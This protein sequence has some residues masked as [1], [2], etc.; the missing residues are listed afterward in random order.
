MK[1][2]KKIIL[3]SLAAI[4]L[5]VAAIAITAVLLVKNSASF[6]HYLMAKAAD[7]I[8]E[9]S[10]A[11]LEA[12]DFTLDLS[13]LSVDLRNVVLRGAEPADAEPLLEAEHL[14]IGITVD[15]VLRRKWHFR[16]GMLSHPVVHLF[17]NRAGESNLPR[18]QGKA[19]GSTAGMFDL[20]IRRLVLERG[21]VYYN[22][23]KRQLD[24]DL[25]HL[26]LAVGFD[27]TQ[28][29]Y[30]GH[31]SYDQGHV[32][33]GSYAPP[34][35]SLDASFSAT[36][37]KLT[38]D[39]LQ[40]ATEKSQIV[41]NA[42]VEDY[43]NPRVQANYDASLA[44]FELA[45]V[46]KSPPVA[47]GTVRLTGFLKYQNQPGHP[48]LETLSLW[49]MLS[50]PELQVRAPHLQTTVRN[51]GA[52]Y[53][54]EGGNVEVQNLR[55]ELLGGT[56]EGSAFVRDLTGAGQ[57][58]LEAKL[59][60][61]SLTVLQTAS[62]T[63]PLR[64]AHLEGTINA[65]AE[66]SWAKALKNLVARGNMTIKAA[67][68]QNPPTPLD[69]VIHADYSA[70]SQQVALHQSYL[71]T[72]RNSLAL[73]G[74][75]SRLSQ[76]QFRLQARD[77]HE[78]ELLAGNFMPAQKLDLHGTASLDGSVSGS[79]DNPQVRAQLTA[80]NLR[81]KGTSWK[82]L[83]TG[84]SASPA[85]VS[86]S[87]G[88]LAA[89]Q[90]RIN[91]NV[92]S[93]LKQWTYSPLNQVTAR[94]S[95][96]QV[97]LAG[98]QRLA[99]K[100]YP[101]QGT[102]ALN[103]SVHGTQ[104]NPVGR[105]NVTLTKVKIADE[106]VQLVEAQ[107]QGDGDQVNA[108][109]HA[110]MPAGNIEGTLTYH[111]KTESY[112]GSLQGNDIR[113]EKLSTPAVYH[114]ALSGGMNLHVEG[115]GTLE[116][117]ELVAT[118]AV[119]QLQAQKQA[120]QGLN[121]EVRLQNRIANITLGSEVVA[122]SVKGHGTV[123]IE[124]PYPADLRLDTG[125]IALQSLLA[126]RAPGKMQGVTGET[127]LHASIQGPLADK[128]RLEV[129][130]E[131]PVLTASYKQF[132]LAATSP[133]RLD[134]Q[135][136]VAVL[137]P[138]S[139]QGTGAD[140]QMQA[141][142]PVNNPMAA[143]YLVQGTI[144]LRNAQLLQP[145]LDC[146]G[147]IEFD[148][149]SRRYAAGSDIAGEVRI[150]DASVHTAALPMG[151]DRGN[152]LVR[153]TKDRLDITD[154][155]G[156]V[157]GGTVTVKGGVVYQPRM[158]FNLALAAK[159]MRLRYPQGL[160]TVLDSNLS[161]AGTEQAAVLS[162]QAL[163]DHVSFT[164]EFKLS[165]FVSQFGEEAATSAPGFAQNVK[166]NIALQSTSD[167]HLKSSQL[168]LQGSA[169]LRI[170]GTAAA[171]VILGRANLAGGELFLAGN[172]YVM[173]SG[174]VS[175]LNPVRTQPVVNLRIRTTVDQYNVALN[176][177]GALERLQINYTSDPALPPADI[178]NLLAFGKTTEAA[179]ASPIPTSRLGAQ[180]V[181]AQGIG[182]VV[183]SSVAKFAG[184]PHFTVDPGLG[185]SGQDPGARITV[186]Q[187][188]TSN[189]YVTYATD[190]TSTQRPAIALEYRF[191]RK[192][193]VNGVR[194]QNGGFGVTGHYRKDF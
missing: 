100:T 111:P 163:I 124:A 117:P 107:L 9:S 40:L 77:L 24:G 44:T 80:T 53:R 84:I 29:R 182:S 71:R 166:L 55:A 172:R 86:L 180:S 22:D 108:N 142:V 126:L 92:Q 57:G 56:L 52:K 85:Q 76:L 91:F 93:E 50:S 147:R 62:R 66:V 157:G 152:G 5:S 118:M 82:R 168:S 190:V 145:G 151:L 11:R 46:I 94:I 162:G 68:G 28:S 127:E 173:E 17:M 99:N 106:K 72:P 96:S 48:L 6:R 10:G 47:L 19:S 148:I 123:G 136:G 155:Q 63:N 27:P 159:G 194:D 69:G 87:N 192:W 191:S 31:L 12:S 34:V 119:P 36:P 187:R 49:G 112:Q 139:I 176:I 156:E 101:I 78:L 38:V 170:A 188:V 140:I 165:S 3:W 128:A 178:I 37:K 54:L 95:A 167:V 143:F 171:P 114:I 45:Q 33:Y 13:R 150:V 58:R 67:L 186:Q 60:N 41:M 30:E 2:T 64:E 120:I 8:Y 104:L 23:S 75:I 115:R 129:H 122:T 174:T 130:A 179:G 61:A 105:G 102:L 160:R 26:E 175:F 138:V 51:L 169:N 39:R 109:L 15:S 144:D 137:Q 25:H 43:G 42:S 154:F 83:R 16:E 21:E 7:N 4:V 184:L 18:P 97:S 70:A 183:S 193:S 161:L 153:V 20:G 98:L 133:V 35:H 59:K 146:T 149:D 73:D 141:K 134:Y 81:I 132:Q 181:L 110:R 189:L 89:T 116:N 79:L 113:L 14:R 164:P 185:G 125:R 65:D 88:E 177:E 90:G 32:K 121:L 131:A 158:Q 103:L 74:T 1:R 135:N